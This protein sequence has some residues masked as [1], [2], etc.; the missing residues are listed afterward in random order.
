MQVVVVPE[1]GRADAT[2][3]IAVQVHVLRVLHAIHRFQLLVN[4]WE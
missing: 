3:Q 4:H 1:T 2:A